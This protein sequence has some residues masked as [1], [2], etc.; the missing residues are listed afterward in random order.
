[1][2]V[3][4]RI[5]I[6]S[7][8][9]CVACQAQLPILPAMQPVSGAVA[10]NLNGVAYRWVASDLTTNVAISGNWADEI[11]GAIWQM[12]A[13]TKQPTNAAT[14]I[15]F[16]ENHYLTNNNTITFTTNVSFGFIFNMTPPAAGGQIHPSILNNTASITSDGATVIGWMFDFNGSSYALSVEANSTFTHLSESPFSDTNRFTDLVCS[17][18]MTNLGASLNLAWT[19]YTNGIKCVRSVGG[20]APP[21]GG[22][23]WASLTTP[24]SPAFC[25]S[26]G[27]NRARTS[28]A[29]FR[30]TEL[31]IWTNSVVSGTDGQDLTAGQLADFHR[32]A[33]NT[34]GGSP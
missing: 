24:P 4:L 8:L 9:L 25:N 31:W 5:N 2:L 12:G 27:F 33:T 20:G 1:M 32:W 30:L 11:Q 6:V 26:L 16:D 10:P 15:W 19:T 21:G 17:Q 14:G 18:C 28:S 29:R 22:K 7:L 23:F 34:Y 3:Y 13:A